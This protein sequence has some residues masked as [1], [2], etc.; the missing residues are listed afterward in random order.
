MKPI[1]FLKPEIAEKIEALTAN[2]SDKNPIFKLV[3]LYNIFSTQDKTTLYNILSIQNNSKPFDEQTAHE[4]R[5]IIEN[6]PEQLLL[7]FA[8]YDTQNTSHAAF[9]TPISNDFDCITYIRK[10]KDLNPTAVASILKRKDSDIEFDLTLV[11]TYE[12]NSNS[13]QEPYIKSYLYGN[14]YDEDWEYVQKT[15]FSDIDD[16]IKNNE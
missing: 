14:P 12:L 7:H 9:V 3:T 2:F 8:T 6:H 5:D 16:V 11:D 4:I 10:N 13:L 15:N 1:K